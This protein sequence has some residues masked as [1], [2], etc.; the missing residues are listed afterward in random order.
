MSDKH[1][2]TLHSNEVNELIGSIPSRITFRGAGVIILA[3]IAITALSGLIPYP[4]MIKV[5][6]SIIPDSAVVMKLGNK[7]AVEGVQLLPGSYSQPGVTAALALVK[8]VPPENCFIYLVNSRYLQQQA[9]PATG[10]LVTLKVNK[11]RK[12]AFTLKCRVKGID[13]A[14]AGNGILLIT[15]EPLREGNNDL[16]AQI[17]L[18]QQYDA[19]I[20]LKENSLLT[21]LLDKLTHPF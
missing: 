16:P 12:D 3:T 8:I 14:T 1:P 9:L 10:Q 2:I 19:D 11:A 7:P 6:G 4:A 5:S 20:I 18:Q 13:S 17:S 21:S 15:L